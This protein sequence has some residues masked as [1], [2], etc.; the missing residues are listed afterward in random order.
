V[1]AVGGEVEGGEEDGDEERDAND[2]LP[3]LRLPLRQLALVLLQR[4]GVHL[5]VH[6]EVEVD[7][8][9][10]RTDE[11]AHRRNLK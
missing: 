11:A 4:L 7:F 5:K 10:P 6:L 8:A 1:R 9:D 2:D 3:Q